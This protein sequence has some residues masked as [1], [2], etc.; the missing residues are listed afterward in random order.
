MLTFTRL[1]W[2]MVIVVAGV[3]GGTL[4]GFAQREASA[5]LKETHQV[6]INTTARY[7]QGAVGSARNS[8][9]NLEYIY[10]RVWTTESWPDEVACYARQS[11]SNPPQ[12]S[13]VVLSDKFGETAKSINGDSFL[14][15]VWD[16]SGEC[17]ELTLHQGS[18]YVPKAP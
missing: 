2:G 4:V 7:A 15:F 12:A 11:G 18:Q 13:C 16:D 14:R 3:V 1:K 9:S 6:L 8:T 5:G 10:C 17:K